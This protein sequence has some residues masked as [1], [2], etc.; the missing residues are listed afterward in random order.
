MYQAMRMGGR[1]HVTGVCTKPR[2][3]V[4]VCT[5]CIRPPILLTWY[6]PISRVYDH[7]FSWL[8]TY[9]CHVYTTTHSPGLVHTPITCIRPPILLALYIPLSRAYDHPFSWLGTY[10]YHVHTTKRRGG[11]MH[12]I[13]VCTKPGE[14][15]V[16]YT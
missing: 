8:G 13:G 5:T 16:V 10:P 15:V 11:R 14:W 4:V 7:P 1:M 3:W 6:I 9:P 12:V 2:E